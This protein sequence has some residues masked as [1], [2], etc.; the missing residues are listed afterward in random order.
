MANNGL[1]GRPILISGRPVRNHVR[2]YFRRVTVARLSVARRHGAGRPGACPPTQCRCTWAG[3]PILENG[4][5]GLQEPRGASCGHWGYPRAFS[6]SAALQRRLGASGDALS[7]AW[8]PA[9]DNVHARERQT[10]V[11]G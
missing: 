3:R 10:L 7:P 9:A 4:R 2:G 11:T 5:Q 8:C 1:D 6:A